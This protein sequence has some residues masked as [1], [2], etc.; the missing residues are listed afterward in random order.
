[1]AQ[2]LFTKY[3]RT[4]TTTKDLAEV[5]RENIHELARIGCGTVSYRDDPPTLSF[6]GTEASHRVTADDGVMVELVT[7]PETGEPCL[8]PIQRRA[9]EAE[10][11][12]APHS[13][14][15]G[16]TEVMEAISTALIQGRFDMSVIHLGE[17]E[18]EIVVSPQGKK[19]VVIDLH[20][21]GGEVI[22]KTQTQTFSTAGRYE[23]FNAEQFDWT[24]I[25]GDI[26]AV[27]AELIPFV[28]KQLAERQGH[29]DR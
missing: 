1:M 8:V 23:V 2:E 28:S 11:G 27:V 10:F 21:S 9:V 7:H 15:F 12:E 5:T 25:E 17:S 22:T 18:G 16:L 19:R 26:E 24:V 14:G 4:V 20:H 29:D 6:E 3:T 13:E